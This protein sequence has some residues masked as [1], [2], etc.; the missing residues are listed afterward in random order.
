MFLYLLNILAV[1]CFVLFGAFFNKKKV[2]KI[3]M[4]GVIICCS[5]MP[6]FKNYNVG[7]D[8]PYYI[9]MF[10]WN[11]DYFEW[12]EKGIEP[13]FFLCI[14]MLQKL[15]IENYSFYF[16]FFS[17]L[18]NFLIIKTI[19]KINKYK[20]VCLISYLTF[21]FVYLLNFNILRQSLALAFFVYSIP[22]IF[23]GKN[24]KS[25]FFILIAIMFHYSALILIS[26]PIIYKFIDKKFHILSILS[27]FFVVFYALFTEK[28]LNILIG[29]SGAE[30]YSA[31]AFETENKGSLLL[32]SVYGFVFVFSLIVKYLLDINDK[33][34][35]LMLYFLMMYS[36]INFSIFFLG[37]SYE[38]PGRV[39]VYYVIGYI[40]IFSYLLNMIRGNRDLKAICTIFIV[41]IMIMFFIVLMSKSNIHEVFPYE[42]AK[43]IW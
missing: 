23:E 13:G 9:N 35:L 15:G 19:Y 39:V 12:I 6:A 20:V 37:L 5:I 29:L 26:V 31:Y 25:Y 21:S 43:N 2:E 3:S 11:L 10:S 28:F 18:F 24:L 40:F 30:R 7:T 17:V 38:G 14:Q 42:F 22:F 8:S 33:K 36:I 27:S 41:F 4:W 32:V 1:F 34:Y 16:L